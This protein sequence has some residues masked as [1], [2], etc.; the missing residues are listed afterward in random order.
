MDVRRTIDA[1]T[2]VALSA[3]IGTVAFVALMPMLVFGLG[4]LV[5]AL[6]GAPLVALV[7]VF[8]HLLARA[9]RRRAAAL[10]GVEF[11]SRT[12]P[13]DGSLPA[14]ALAWMRSRGSWLEL[15]YAIVALPF[16]GWVGG[17]LVFMAWGAALAFL[18][19]PLW[20]W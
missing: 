19:F 11:P 5:L 8:C 7:F 3:A 1:T 20:G 4:S 12:L 10:L 13:R 9:E 16:V 14:R 18:T 6:A 2:Y 17:A 15:C